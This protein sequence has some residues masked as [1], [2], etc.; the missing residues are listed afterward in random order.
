MSYI[1]VIPPRK[2]ES[3][4]RSKRTVR[5]YLRPKYKKLSNTYWRWH[6]KIEFHGINLL[7]PSN[8]TSCFWMPSSSHLLEAHRAEINEPPSYLQSSSDRP[9]GRLIY[10]NVGRRRSRCQLQPHRHLN[11]IVSVTVGLVS[12]AAVAPREVRAQR[13]VAAQTILKKKWQI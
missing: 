3:W 7:L 13:A 2:N 4:K 11:A 6:H 1:Y 12:I 9:M 8:G 5:I 10:G